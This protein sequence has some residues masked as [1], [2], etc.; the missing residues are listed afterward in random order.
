L[1][2]VAIGYDPYQVQKMQDLTTKVAKLKEELKDNV[3]QLYLYGHTTEGVPI[4]QILDNWLK[5]V[6]TY[7]ESRAAYLY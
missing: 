4:A 1:N 3:H 2:K 5:N 7:E 6:I